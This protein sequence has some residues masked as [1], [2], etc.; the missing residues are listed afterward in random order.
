MPSKIKKGDK[1]FV[2]AGKDK[3]KEGEVL[4]ILK[5]NQAFSA[6]EREHKKKNIS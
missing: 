5:N 3:G 4:R 1:V 2:I 6:K